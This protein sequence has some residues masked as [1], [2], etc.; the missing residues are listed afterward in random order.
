MRDVL[1]ASTFVQLVILARGTRGDTYQ[2]GF[3]VSKC[4]VLFHCFLKV[5][6]CN[7]VVAL[8][9][10][11]FP[12]KHCLANLEDYVRLVREVTTNAG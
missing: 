4:I 1:V 10:G 11:Y 6:K 12:I 7:I 5:S 3:C 9:I 2:P 8:I